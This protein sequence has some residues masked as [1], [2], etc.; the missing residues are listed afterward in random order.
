MLADGR[1]ETEELEPLL[2]W[3]TA[4]R[5]T[6]GRST[7]IEVG[8]NVGT[9]TVPLCQHG[10]HVIAFEPIP[11]LRSLLIENLTSNGVLDLAS[12]QSLAIAEHEGEVEMRVSDSGGSEIVTDS[13]QSIA[14][15]RGPEYFSGRQAT[16]GTENLIRVAT[17]P[18]DR[19][20][21]DLGIDAEDVLVVWSDTEGAETGVIAGGAHLW[22]AG[23]PL[24]L[25]VWPVGLDEHDGLDSFFAAVDEHFVGFVDRED[26]IS[27]TERAPVRELSSLGSQLR[28]ALETQSAHWSIDVL[29]VPPSMSAVRA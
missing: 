29:L 14:D 27:L 21:A 8:A 6:R 3:V 16:G 11:R 24:W 19:A 15:R 18:L 28:R 10:Q 12:V 23:V 20:L 25:E 17:R 7:V 1:Y 22:G 26:L 9:T 4:R 2:A 5:T 13:V